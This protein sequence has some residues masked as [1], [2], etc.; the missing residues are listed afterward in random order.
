MWAACTIVVASLWVLVQW[1]SLYAPYTPPTLLHALSNLERAGTP[2][3]LPRQVL[4]Q[5][6]NVTILTDLDAVSYTHL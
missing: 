3:R 6:Y 4:P 5:H 2:S 1:I